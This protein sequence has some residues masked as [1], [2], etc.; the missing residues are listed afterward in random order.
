MLSI[1]IVFFYGCKKDKISTSSS[2]KLLLS[3]D[4]LKFDTLFTS[5]GSTTKVFTLKNETDKI[6]L[7]KDFKLLSG[8]SSYYRVNIDG[9][10]MS[11]TMEI[12]IPSRD[13]IYVFVEVTIDPNSDALPFV[14]EDA[15]QMNTNGNIQ[16][17]VL[18][19]YGQNAHFYDG[20]EI[21]TEVW[22]DDIPYVILN[23]ILVKEGHTLTIDPGVEVYFGGNSGMFVQGT[24][25]V[26]GTCAQ[27]VEFRC[28]RKDKLETGIPY[29][30]LPGQWLGLFFLRKSTSNSI[31]HLYIRGSQYGM[32][33]GNTTFEDFPLLPAFPPDVTI[34]NSEI[35][36][37]SFYGIFAFN[38]IIDAENLLVTQCGKQALSLVLGGDYQFRNSTFFVR[39]T[40]TIE[41]K[42]PLLYF[43]NFHVYDITKPALQFSLNRCEFT[44]CIFYG[45][46]EDEI[47]PDNIESA[48]IDFNYAFRNCL[49]RTKLNTTGLPYTSCIFNQDP[50]FVDLFKNDFHLDTGSVCIDAGTL[51]SLTDITCKT[52]DAMP[53]IGAYE[54]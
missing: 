9:D 22:H 33:V 50:L 35:Y 30:D 10:I 2:D 11:P 47:L 48:G 21:E 3:T 4:T 5:L 15:L 34:S 44:N 7:V 53:D 12:Q 28:L 49:I 13:S 54:Y 1:F 8:S 41:H 46:K 17:V 29:Y 14:I 45:N 42:D 6:L 20:V 24:L 26:E 25:N 19:A 39:S 27:K 43:S 32:N 51:G 40:N 37:S 36:N 38:G 18:Q 23:S 31:E 52:R 16:Q